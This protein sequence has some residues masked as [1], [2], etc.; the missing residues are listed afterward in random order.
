MDWDLG[1]CTHKLYQHSTLHLRKE[2]LL[3]LGLAPQG[4]E[5]K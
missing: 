5:D 4:E 3:P 2:R 1:G